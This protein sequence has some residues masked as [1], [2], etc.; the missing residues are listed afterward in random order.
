MARVA[1]LAGLQDQGHG[2]VAENGIIE[3]VSCKNFMCHANLTVKLGPRINFIIG[4]NG[5]GK[6]AVLTALTICLGG[7]ATATNRGQ[8]LK[9][10]IKAGAEQCTLSVK[11]KNQG[12]TAYEPQTYGESIIVERV[13]SRSGTSGFKIKR[14]DGRVQSTRK[15]DL[16][17]ILDALALMMDNPMNVLTQDM[18]RQFLNSSNAAEKYKFFYQGTHLEQLDSDYRILAES[19][20]QNQDQIYNLEKSA[21]AAKNN[22][23][24][25]EKKAE[26]AERHATMLDKYNEL[27]R[28]MAWIQVQIEEEKLAEMEQQIRDQDDVIEE[29][30]AAFAEY[31][32]DMERYNGLRDAAKA[33]VDA[34]KADKATKAEERDSVKEIFD[35]NRSKLSDNQYEERTI[36]SKLKLSKKEFENKQAEVEREKEKIASADDGRHAVKMDQIQ[37]AE[38]KLSSLQEQMQQKSAESRP[39]DVAVRTAEESEKVSNHAVEASNTNIRSTEARIASI[40]RAQGDWREAFLKVRELQA[41]LNLIDQE[42]GF[43]V[44]PIGPIGRH[45]KLLE[46]HKQWADI[47][48]T[49]SG[50][51]LDGFV[52]ASKA[53]QSILSGLMKRSRYQARIFMVPTGPLDTS[54]KE[55]A[56]KYL[57]WMRA[58]RIDNVLVRNCMILN[59][60]FEQT[61]LEEDSEKA[62]HMISEGIANVLRIYAHQGRGENGE[63][64]GRSYSLTTSKQEASGPINP[65]K[66]GARMQRDTGS[67]IS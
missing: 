5:S 16:E 30:R 4:H 10:F 37:A 24:E 27:R 60:G 38:E 14:A 34:A 51:T 54:N 21:Q 11:I 26:L 42:R 46:E 17:D 62:S 56:E 47:L 12:E 18:A 36:V 40:Q 57:T 19:L 61:V 63:K 49:S 58:L 8:N 41:L 25:A 6:S 39:L 67:E 53:D 1:A 7:K 35:E 50:A 13:F 23:I 9:A 29:R 59:H 44:K 3:E 66:R 22:Y 28:Q 33:A 20:Q 48:E 64:W 52:C 31:D 65:W 45:I 32:A 55:P 15:S 2:R 43:K